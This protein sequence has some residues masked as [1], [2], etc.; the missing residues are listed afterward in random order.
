MARD[1]AFGSSEGALEDTAMVKTVKQFLQSHAAKTEELKDNVKQQTGVRANGEV[2][3]TLLK[4][5][6]R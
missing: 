1:A 6:H 5:E 4:L 2:L 3:V